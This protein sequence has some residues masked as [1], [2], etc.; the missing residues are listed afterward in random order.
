[1][2]AIAV[3]TLLQPVDIESLRTGSVLTMSTRN[4][5]RILQLWKILHGPVHL[6]RLH[7]SRTAA[8]LSTHSTADCLQH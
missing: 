2:I 1:M 7:D 4:L 6:Y 8:T 3:A 5:C